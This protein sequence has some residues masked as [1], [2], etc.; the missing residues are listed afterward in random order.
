MHFPGKG[1]GIGN[2]LE[3]QK[4]NYMLILG[5]NVPT[6]YIQVRLEFFIFPMCFIYSSKSSSTQNGR[7][8]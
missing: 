3:S 4:G 8:R 2:S 6:V 7:T 5:L 1:P